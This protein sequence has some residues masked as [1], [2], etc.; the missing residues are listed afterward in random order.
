MGERNTATALAI[1]KANPNR[2]AYAKRV[3]FFRTWSTLGM[4]MAKK[5]AN[6]AALSANHGLEAWPHFMTIWQAVVF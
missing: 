2:K 3:G 6:K 5:R 1:S 4:S